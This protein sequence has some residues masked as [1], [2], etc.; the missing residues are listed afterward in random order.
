MQAVSASRQAKRKGK[1]ARIVIHVKCSMF[2][3]TSQDYPELRA[4]PRREYYSLV[5]VS[6]QDYFLGN[7]V[8]Y[9]QENPI[10]NALFGNFNVFCM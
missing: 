6:P 10:A 4:H 5:H 9:E 8:N 2:W 1:G 7:V 3:K